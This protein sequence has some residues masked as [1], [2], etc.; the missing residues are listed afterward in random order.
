VSGNAAA[1][2]MSTGT[3][4]IPMMIQANFTRNFASAV[5]AV[6]STGGQLMPP[7]MGAAAFVMAELSGVSYVQIIKHAVLPSFMY[8]LALFLTIDFEAR[9]QNLK[10]LQISDSL[11]LKDVMIGKGHLLLPVL[12]LVAVLVKGYTAVFSALCGTLAIVGI[13]WLRRATRLDVKKILLALRNGAMNI[14]PVAAACATA[15]IVLGVL[16]L[17]ALGL[18][19][20]S[21]IISLAGSNLLMA[22]L[23]TMMAGIILG[24]GLPTTPAYIIQAALLVPALI[25]LGVHP[26][27]AHFFV[28]YFACL[29]SITPPVSLAVYAAVA[30]GHG[31]LW[32]TGL[33]ALR[34]GLVGFIVPFVFVFSPALLM[35]GSGMKIVQ[36]VL[37][38]TFA[39]CAFAAGVSG[40]MK[41]PLLG[42][43]RILMIVSGGF[44]IVPEIISDLIGLGLLAAYLL[45]VWVKSGKK[46][47]E[48]I[49]EA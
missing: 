21:L 1:N 31:N 45:H 44:L 12:V 29:S 6:A 3:F 30:I 37:T 25:E 10:G 22:L 13:S 15:G 46:G 39:V 7:I 11:P 35:I 49:N 26:L 19:F 8:Y 14:I 27:A 20:T 18:K 16:N 33:H 9:R 5:E 42:Y 28:L 2:V 4:T 41:R 40:W 23:L 47:L 36:V 48:D 24:M 17:T 34:L 43:E 32:R 38:T